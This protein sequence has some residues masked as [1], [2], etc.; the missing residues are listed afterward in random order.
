L[1]QR[2]LIPIASL[3]LLPA[4]LAGCGGSDTSPE[5][6]WAQ[7]FCESIGTWK[8][9]LTDAAKPLTDPS[10][11]S[12]SSVQDAATSISSA[13]SQLVGDLKA[14]G[15]PSGSSGS[16][17]QDDVQELSSQIQDDATK[18]KNSMEGVSTT[19]ELMSAIP[20]LAAT[21]S[22]A[23]SSVSATITKLESQS[24]A[25]KQAFEDSDACKSLKKD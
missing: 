11:L 24:D 7:S 4:L 5:A 6:S 1:R 17:A 13:N 9:S 15:K 21:A 23:A 14:L 3:L 20:T 10:N 12:K 18:A 19:Q 8:T 22:S 16:A 25:W 2:V